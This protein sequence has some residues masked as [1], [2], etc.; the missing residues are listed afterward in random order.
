[1]IL[2][3]REQWLLWLMVDVVTAVMWLIPNDILS[4]MEWPE[5]KYELADTACCHDRKS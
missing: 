2:G 1:M 5:N 3:Y 4:W